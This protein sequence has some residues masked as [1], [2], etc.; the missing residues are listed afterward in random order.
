MEVDD[1]LVNCLVDLRSLHSLIAKREGMSY[2]H[3]RR[4]ITRH[5]VKR[6]PIVIQRSEMKFYGFVPYQ[7]TPSV[8]DDTEGEL[9]HK[10]FDDR[11]L[12][13]APLRTDTTACA[14]A[15]LFRSCIVIEVDDESGA[16][17]IDS[18]TRSISRLD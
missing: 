16:I 17:Y 14:I 10:Y 18:L 5:V 9:M 11:G 8:T 15:R 7:C 1:T 6:D 2:P 13:L 12:L 4:Y 3:F